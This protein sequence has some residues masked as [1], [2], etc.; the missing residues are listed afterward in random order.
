MVAIR[1]DR[2]GENE[3]VDAVD[4]VEAEEMLGATEGGGVTTLGSARWSFRLLF[5][6][7]SPSTALSED[8]ESKVP[9]SFF[10][11]FFSFGAFNTDD[12]ANIG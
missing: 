10:W 9:P 2:R 11:H 8:G 4:A 3:S 1:L 12:R 7:A 5:V 6:S